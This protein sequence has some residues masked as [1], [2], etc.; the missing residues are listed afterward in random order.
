MTSDIV[1]A[2]VGAPYDGAATLGWPGARHAP[3]ERCGGTSRG[4]LNPR[5]DTRAQSSILAA[6]LVFQFAVAAVQRAG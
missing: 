1:V 5:T 2:L 3:D 4:L 6:S